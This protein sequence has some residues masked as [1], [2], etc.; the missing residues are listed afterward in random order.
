M[1]NKTSDQ[2]SL[3]SLLEDYNE[4]T[5]KKVCFICKNKTPKRGYHCDI[6]GICI[7]QYDHHCT[8]ICNCVGKK[9]IARFIIFVVLLVI[10][11]AFVGTM[12]VLGS[13]ALLY[14]DPSKF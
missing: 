9:N 10:L 12:A 7:E 5:I 3:D 4:R 8:W 6:C 14:S 1:R 2:K 13:L 11:L